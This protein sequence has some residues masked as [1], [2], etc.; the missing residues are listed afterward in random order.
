MICLFG[1]LIKLAR[2]HQEDGTYETVA[3]KLG[4]DSELVKD[5]ENNITNPEWSVIEKFGAVYGIS[6]EYLKFYIYHDDEPYH[7]S[8]KFRKWSCVKISQVIHKLLQN[9]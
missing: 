5:F 8:K 6:N 7:I 9:S 1:S 2:I 3:E 4:I